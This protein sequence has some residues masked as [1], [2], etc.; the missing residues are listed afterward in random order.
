MGFGFFLSS[1]VRDRKKI[2]PLS[3]KVKIKKVKDIYFARKW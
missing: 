1:D 3:L 2:A